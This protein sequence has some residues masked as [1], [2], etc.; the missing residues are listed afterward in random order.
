MNFLRTPLPLWRPVLLCSLLSSTLGCAQ[1]QTPNQALQLA[2]ELQNVARQSEPGAPYINSWLVLGPFDNDAQNSGFNYT[3]V[4]EASAAPGQGQFERRPLS[5]D[6]ARR[7]SAARVVE[8]QRRF[9]RR[10]DARK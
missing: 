8:N 10:F 6:R 4:D 5:I 3:F 2:A 9:A 1:A 7:G